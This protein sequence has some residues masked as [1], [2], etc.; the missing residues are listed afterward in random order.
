[1]PYFIDFRMHKFH[2]LVSLKQ[3]C[4]WGSQ[5]KN[6]EVVC[7]S[8]LQWT[9]FC[10][11]LTSR[12]RPFSAQHSWM[13]CLVPWLSLLVHV[14]HLNLHWSSDISQH[15]SRAR[16]KGPAGEAAKEG[17]LQPALEDSHELR[18][19]HPHS[20]HWPQ[21]SRSA[22]RELLFIIQ[23]SSVAQLCPILCD[24][25]ECSTPDFPVHHQ[26]PELTQ[27][28]VLEPVMPSNYLILC[29][30]LLLLPSLFPSIRVF[31]NESVLRIR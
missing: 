16:G 1:M 19:A 27:V 14:E 31:S 5:G 15:M 3:N 26:L 11:A 18:A 2:N 21:W 13:T 7:H 9:M 23:F 29:L 8:F 28:H 24:C 20:C 25:M 10:Q 22:S 6:T 4:S 30:P 12:D 17:R